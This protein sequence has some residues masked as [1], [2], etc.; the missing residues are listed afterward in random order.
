VIFS[1]RF[2]RYINTRKHSLLNTLNR[3]QLWSA[4]N[5]YKRI[6]QNRPI[7]R[8]NHLSADS[9]GCS[10]LSEH[11]IVN[12][13]QHFHNTFS[14]VRFDFEE[15]IARCGRE[16]ELCASEFRSAAPKPRPSR[17]TRSG[18]RSASQRFPLYAKSSGQR[19][20]CTRKRLQRRQVSSLL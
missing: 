5:F 18:A 19:L 20:Q 2:L 10:I 6:L 11:Q 14:A 1:T 16:M 8:G 7:F 4:I 17:T 3:A 15:R 12:T 13:F 9:A